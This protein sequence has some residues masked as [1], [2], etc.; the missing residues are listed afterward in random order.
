MKAAVMNEK[1]EVKVMDVPEPQMEPDDI[2]VRIAYCGVCGSE[3]HMFDPAFA[4]GMGRPQQ[5]PSVPRPGLRIMGHESSGTIVEI[6]NGCKQGYKVGQK[7][8]MNFR[9]P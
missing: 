8:A 6:G 2:K 1:R 5:K 9:S 3:L 7:V 4:S